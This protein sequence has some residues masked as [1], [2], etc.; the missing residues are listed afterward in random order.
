MTHLVQLLQIPCPSF[1]Q[2]PPCQG[3][4]AQ[5]R[6]EVLLVGIPACGASTHARTHA[7]QRGQ[8]G[9]QRHAI[10]EWVRSCNHH[11]NHPHALKTQQQGITTSPALHLTKGESA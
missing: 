9:T 2:L 11:R 4:K 5:A 7:S 6:D 8:S 10:A 1:Q 3:D